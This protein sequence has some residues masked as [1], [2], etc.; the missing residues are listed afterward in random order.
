MSV[1]LSIDPGLNNTGIAVIDPMFNCKVLET[2]LVKNTR[3][4]TDAEKLVEARYGH[5]AVKVNAILAQLNHVLERYQPTQIVS[6]APF[7]N[8]Q[9]PAAYG[10]LVEIVVSIKY[11]VAMKHQLDFFT[12][13]PLLVKKFFT[14]RGMAP[15]DLMK[16]FLRS[17]KADGSILI[18]SDVET[19]SEHEID[20]VAVG[21]AHYAHLQQKLQENAS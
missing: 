13:E 17:R 4:F 15:K 7:Y 8:H 14:S 19:L 20:A 6:E 3:K 12:V 10:S 11:N 1:F 2:I 5:R 16:Q 21:Y 9:T 18:D